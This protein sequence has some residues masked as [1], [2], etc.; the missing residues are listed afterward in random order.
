M[1]GVKWNRAMRSRVQWH[2]DILFGQ[3]HARATILDV[4]GGP[5]H[6]RAAILSEL[7]IRSMP[8]QPF[9]HSERSGACSG[10]HFERTSGFEREYGVFRGVLGTKLWKLW[11]SG[12]PG[13]SRNF[14][15]IFIYIRIREIGHIAISM[16]SFQTLITFRGGFAGNNLIMHGHRWFDGGIGQNQA[17]C[18]F[19]EFGLW[20]CCGCGPRGRRQDHC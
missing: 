12:A 11:S 15:Y 19:G 1:H 16:E 6:V 8:E 13:C 14:V 20:P 4:L 2:R 18:V 10:S 17:P 7:G 5:K 9:E 3:K